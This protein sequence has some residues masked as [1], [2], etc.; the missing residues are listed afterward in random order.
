MAL[1]DMTV[2]SV[3]RLP[4]PGAAAQKRGAL[5]KSVWILN[6]FGLWRDLAHRSIRV[7]S[8]KPGEPL[9]R[10]V[11]SSDRLVMAVESALLLVLVLAWF[12]IP[13]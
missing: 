5:K 1:E 8:L 7:L 10:H 6:L 9:W 13:A 3:C 11:M 2:L 12:Y 4:N